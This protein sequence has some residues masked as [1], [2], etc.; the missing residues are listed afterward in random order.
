ML[1][2]IV[3]SKGDKMIVKSKE[4]KRNSFYGVDFV[5]LSHGQKSMVTKMLYKSDDK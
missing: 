5:V 1:N 2:S 4:A 3:Y